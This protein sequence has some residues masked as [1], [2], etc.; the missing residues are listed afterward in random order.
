MTDK[1]GGCQREIVR[2]SELLLNARSGHE[3]THCSPVVCTDDNTAVE[4]N[5][6]RTRSSLYCSHVRFHIN[7]LQESAQMHFGDDVSRRGSLLNP[8][9]DVPLA[10]L[11]AS[12]VAT[13]LEPMKSKES[14][15]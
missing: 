13:V 9:S 6:Y 11:S 5:P 2:D 3:M 12:G 7:I 8:S 10:H 4:T 1:S 15:D 14:E